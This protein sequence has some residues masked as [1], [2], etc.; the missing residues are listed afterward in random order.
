MKVR[1]VKK[2]TITKYVN[3]NR[4]S[5]A[6]FDTWLNKLKHANWK[7]SNDVTETFKTADFLGKSSD[8]IVFNIGGNNYRMICKY[9]FGRTKVHLFIMWIQCR[10]VKQ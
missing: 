2:N 6:Y 9:H 7:D 1:L 4:N 5:K 3:G 10:L 8:R